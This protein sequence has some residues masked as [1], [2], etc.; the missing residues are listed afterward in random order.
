MKK[1]FFI[2]AFCSIGLVG[3]NTVPPQ[4][5]TADKTAPLK[6][7]NNRAWNIH[8]TSDGRGD[9]LIPP[10]SYQIVGYFKPGTKPKMAY[11]GPF[12]SYAHGINNSLLGGIV[13]DVI[14]EEG[15]TITL[16]FSGGEEMYGVRDGI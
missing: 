13:T 12:D 5:P 8:V 6:I 4:T 11:Y 14:K 2:L 1:I 7:V 9:I 16:G 10:N 3:C 15:M